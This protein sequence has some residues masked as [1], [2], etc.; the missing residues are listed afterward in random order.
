MLKM[1][2]KLFVSDR[3][4][5]E[6]SHAAMHGRLAPASWD[7]KPPVCIFKSSEL[8]RPGYNEQ[9]NASEY[10]DEPE[11]LLEKVKLL[12]KLIRL[13][14]N[15]CVYSG[16]GI[17]TASGIGDY[18]S[19]STVGDQAV[20]SPYDAQPTLSH[21]VLA[22]LHRKGHVKSWIQ[23]NHDGLP[24][25]A[26]FPQSSLNEIHGSFFDPSNVVVAM[27][28]QLR[29]DLFE[30]LLEC[31]R[32]SDLVL[33]VGTSLSGMNADRVVTSVAK[34]F[35]KHVIAKN[36]ESLIG[37]E[38]T[39]QTDSIGSK[40][41]AI[42]TENNAIGSNN[43]VTFSDKITQDLD[44]FGSVIISLQQTPQD[45]ECSLR[46]FG[47]LDHVMSLVA[48]EM[49]L[50]TENLSNRKLPNVSDFL[51]DNHHRKIRGQIGELG[52]DDIFWVPYDS[53]GFLLSENDRSLLHLDLREGAMV[54]ITA[55]PH[56]GDT[57][58]VV[59]KHKEG[60]YQIRF[61]HEIGLQWGR[62]SFKAPM[63][64]LLGLWWPLCAV[65]GSIGRL[66]V[67]NCEQN[68]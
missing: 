27:S 32:N 67:V 24:Q 15:M 14:K 11:I 33:A 30:N 23:Q 53:E 46:I 62:K 55:G 8:A 41:G 36:G 22:D 26:G 54:K 13:S 59:G 34:R 57:G 61:M 66:P 43:D 37:P 1:M 52:V 51:N 44:V 31:E 16:A 3:T 25:K 4:Y 18:A 68:E 65:E 19:R 58:E 9:T 17:S 64:R 49:G 35:A 5:L 7:A 63:T 56:A 28:G 39:I 29:S 20:R 45:E 12:A 21:Y 40:H 48:K 6:A 10:E 42:D 60:H 2:G 47:K 50:D 38:T